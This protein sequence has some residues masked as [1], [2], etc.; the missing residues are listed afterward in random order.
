MPALLNNVDPDGLLE[1]SVV[2][3]DRSLNHMS[4]TFQEVMRDIS[5]CLKNAYN[6][7]S[8]VVVPGSG[9][10]AME[11]VARQFATG[12]KCL[13]IRNGLFSFRWSQIF[14]MGDIPSESI[15]LKARPVEVVNQAAFAPVPIDEVVTMIQTQKPDLVFA[16]HVET[17]AGMIL[18]DDYIK[19]IADAIHSVGG[20]LV[21]DCI[22][23]GAVWVDM[24]ACGVDILLSAPQKGWSSFPCCGLVMLS[25]VA[26]DV[27]QST[28]ST[29][30]ACDLRKWHEIMTA[31]EN[32]SHAYHATMPTDGLRRFRDM[33]KET[34]TFGFEK[35][36]SAQQELGE[37]VKTVLN[38]KNI[39]IL[40]A[41]GYQ[42]PGVIVCYTDSNDIHNG[43][44]FIEA[45][46]QIAPGVPI[47]CDEPNTFKT[48][49]I[50]LFGLDKLR[51]IDGTVKRLEA[52]LEQVIH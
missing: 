23:S 46:I 48:F 9:T 40:A 24:K 17:S 34:E 39:K 8:V 45:G 16:P 2:F 32:N 51:D 27:L 26:K 4:Q 14:D 36:K 22:A 7:E 19:R 43:K 10:F 50:G 13:I 41:D 1:Y 35:I 33:I 5:T 42:A 20:M 49:R 15:V 31:Y 3:T 47:Q 52:A 28:T 6:A 21:L 38:E 12:K 30:F 18:P 37:K 29:S 25:P 11:A 44:K